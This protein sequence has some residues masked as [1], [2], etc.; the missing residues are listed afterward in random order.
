[1]DIPNTLFGFY[2]ALV[3]GN[4][5]LDFKGRIIVWIPQ[6]MPEIE[7]DRGL[8]ALPANNPVGGRNEEGDNEHHYMGT[9]YIPKR[10]S[11]V[12][13]FFEAGNPS[14]P[15]YFGAC[16]LENTTVL[17]E[18]Q[19]GGEPEDKWVIFKSHKGRT[20]VI[21]DDPDD[22]RVEITGKKRKLEGSERP[23]GS[24]ESVY[25]IDG[26]QTTILLDERKGKEKLLIR[27]Y[28]GDFVHIDID[29]RNLQIDFENDINI[30]CRGKISIKAHKDIH[31]L[32]E[33]NLHVESK[34]STNVKAGLSIFEYAGKCHH[35]KTGDSI[36]QT[37]GSSHSTQAGSLIARDCN[38]IHDNN[39]VSQ[40]A[41]DA[42]KSN[43]TVP[44]GKRK[45]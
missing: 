32:T 29:Q 25:E 30:E 17:P 5:D 34:L 13:V 14:N 12:F 41:I 2:R 21:S 6:I 1:M 20:V 31:I 22:E 26:N 35:I 11:W 45:T 8:L 10:G 39:G 40:T 19:L 4:K 27:T 16:D 9:S 37:A 7:K 44:D 38:P 23:T 24:L 18:C 36:R 33:K 43:P 3:V 15:Y 28:K 42:A